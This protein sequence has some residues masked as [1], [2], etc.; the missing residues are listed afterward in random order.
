MELRSYG[1][2][3]LGQFYLLK[4]TIIAVYYGKSDSSLVVLGREVKLNKE[5]YYSAYHYGLHLWKDSIT[6]NYMNGGLGGGINEFYKG[7]RISDNP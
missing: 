1:D 7:I 3:R 5:G 2:P 6:S 4:D